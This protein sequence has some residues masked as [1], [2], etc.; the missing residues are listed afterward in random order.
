MALFILISCSAQWETKIFSNPRDTF[1]DN[2]T[3]PSVG[4]CGKCREGSQFPFPNTALST[5]AFGFLL[6][7]ILF[8][9]PHNPTYAAT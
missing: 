3:P 5:V 4:Y 6:T 8:S 2:I 7:G 1:I 9:H